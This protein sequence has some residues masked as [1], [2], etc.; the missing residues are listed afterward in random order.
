LVRGHRGEPSG[1]G[2]NCHLETECA[3]S[4]RPQALDVRWQF[5]PPDLTEESCLFGVGKDYS[6]GMSGAACQEFR[7]TTAPARALP[8]PD[9]DPDADADADI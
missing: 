2:R 5:L 7:R 8:D 9:D 6:A 3:K 4:R 1:D